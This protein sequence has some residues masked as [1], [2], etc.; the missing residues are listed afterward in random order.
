LAETGTARRLRLIVRATIMMGLVVVLA[1]IAGQ[2]FL[3]ALQTS[4]IGR[5]AVLAIL[6]PLGVAV[7]LGALQLFGVAKI[8]D[9]ANA[10]R[11]RT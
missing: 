11:D 6:V 2:R 4:S 7:Y 10:V 1:H 5:L 8:S 3:S 9:L